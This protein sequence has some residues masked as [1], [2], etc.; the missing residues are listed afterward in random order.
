MLRKREVSSLTLNDRKEK[1]HINVV[2]IGHVDS[3]KSTTTGEPWQFFK[4][5]MQLTPPQGI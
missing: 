1:A 2:V 3:G 5:L 4:P